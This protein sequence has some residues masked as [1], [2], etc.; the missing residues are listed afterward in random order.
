M[1]RERAGQTEHWVT[2]ALVGLLKSYIH[3]GIEWVDDLG[4]NILYFKRIHIHIY[5]SPFKNY[6]IHKGVTVHL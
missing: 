4:G 1:A 6:V 5:K 3:I 2:G